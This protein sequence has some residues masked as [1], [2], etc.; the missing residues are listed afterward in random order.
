V[1]CE[2]DKNALIERYGEKYSD[3]A[4]KIFIQINNVNASWMRSC[5]MLKK[6]DDDIITIM[7]I[8]NFSDNRKGHH[9]LLP[10]VKRLIDDGYEIKLYVAGDGEQLKAYQNE[11]KEYKEIVFLGRIR[12]ID[13]YLLASDFELVPSLMDSCPN[14]VLE[15]ISCGV[16]VYGTN[17]GGIKD[18]LKDKNYLFKPSVD[19]LYMFIKNKIDKKEFIDDASRQESIKKRLTFDWGEKILGIIDESNYA[20]ENS[21]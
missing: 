1:Q 9:L 17:V 18:I 14:T 21:V 11:Y 20:M 2:D 13:R 10:A 8:G 15:G 7:F 6:R 4:K 16:A 19:R 3:L 12:D 5:K